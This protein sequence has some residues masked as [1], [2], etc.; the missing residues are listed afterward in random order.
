L[1]PGTLFK[2]P[3][4]VLNFQVGRFSTFGYTNLDFHISAFWI[5]ITYF[6]PKFEVWVK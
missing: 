6:E 3:N 2:V 1:H 4:I 5:E